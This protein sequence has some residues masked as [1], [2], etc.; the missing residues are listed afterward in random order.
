MS[1]NYE[2]VPSPNYA[3]YANPGFGAALGQMLQGLPDQYMKGRQGAQQI[4]LQD[5]FKDGL[6]TKNGRPDIDAI[7]DKLVKIGGAPYAM[8]LLKFLSP[9]PDTGTEP[10][11]GG[12]Q[13]SPSRPAPVSGA[14]GPSSQGAP[15]QPQL[16][17]AGTD[18]KGD[19]TI[20]SLASEVFGERDV[21]NMLPRYAAAVGNKLGEPLTP[22]QE[23][24]ARQMMQRTKGSMASASPG[25]AASTPGAG[26]SGP[27]NSGNA[28]PFMAGGA[29]RAPAAAP[30]QGNGAPPVQVAQ[31]QTGAGTGLP[32]NYTEKK[33]GE[34]ETSERNHMKVA[35]Y[36]AR[37]GNKEAAQNH[38]EQAK[39]AGDT[40]KMIREQ[41]AKNAE[42]SGPAKEARESGVTGGPM[43]MEG[44]KVA[45]KQELTRGDALQK[46]LQGAAREFE[47]A[48][49]PHLDAMRGILNDPNFVSGTGVG[50]QEALNKI[51]SNPLFQGLPG[52]D[53]NAALPNEAIRKV[54]AAS[55]LNQTTE[56][57]AEAAE[58]GGSAG[59]L[60]QQQISLMEKAAQNPEN[61]APALRYLTEL[62]QR[63]GDHSRA[64]AE[65]A[66]TY[67]GKYGRGVL[68]NGFN[69]VLSKF[70]NEPKNQIFHPDEIRDM[71]KFAPPVAPAVH[72]KT[73]ALAWAEKAGI[74]PGDPVKTQS[75]KI[76][77]F[78]PSKFK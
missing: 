33:A 27:Q 55:I 46:G 29:P 63:M 51:R 78:D 54:V 43:A 38:R 22:Q 2:T 56:L 70:N 11:I 5:A 71:R 72:D 69:E 47:T 41:I 68:D 23:Q 16:S 30:A 32:P 13:G 36:Y 19:Q 74:R 17:S 67:Q 31:A 26:A 59:R 7:G 61:T 21:T 6:P 25:D 64:V 53:P 34:Y 35:D 1:V 42:L 28:A 52:Y 75:G 24:A 50:F 49:K 3:A 60:F 57:K 39:Q 9:P 44:L 8:Q 65:L 20:N 76:V 77:T 66:N 58:M 73:E 10:T 37:V 48:L 45:Q 12:D 4:A 14:A 62:Q 18:S 15:P 40:A